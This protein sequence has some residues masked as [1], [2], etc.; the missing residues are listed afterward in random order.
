VLVTL[1]GMLIYKGKFLLGGMNI[2]EFFIIMGI[3]GILFIVGSFLLRK[4]LQVSTSNKMSKRAKRFEYIGI[5]ILFVGYLL[6]VIKFSVGDEN[7]N[8]AIIIFPFV[9]LVSLFRAVMQWKYNREA[10]QWAMELYEAIMYIV[11]LFVMLLVAGPL[12][13]I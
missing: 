6:A 5:A 10:K 9:C 4:K 7:R 12:L 13:G 2:K 1:K 3:V 8:I 11:I